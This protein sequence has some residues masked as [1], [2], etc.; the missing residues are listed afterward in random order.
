[1]KAK[2]CL[3][4]GTGFAGAAVAALFGGWDAAMTTLL[5]F[6]G[7]DIVTG[8]IVAAVFK[9]SKKTSGGKLSSKECF[10]GLCRKFAILVYVLIA[11]RLDLMMGIDYIKDFTVI[12]FCVNEALSIVENSSLMG[13]PL[14][15]VVQKALEILNNKATEKDVEQ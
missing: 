4:L 7:L 9:K 1:M 8:L 10:K 6:M 13:I 12:F 15:P 2:I 3:Q 14:P 5:I 11:Y